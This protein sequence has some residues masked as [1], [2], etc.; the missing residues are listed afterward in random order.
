MIVISRCLEN[1]MSR[2]EDSLTYAQLCAEHPHVELWCDEKSPDSNWDYY[3]VISHP[4]NETVR[5]V[6]YLRTAN[7]QLERRRYDENGDEQWVS[8]R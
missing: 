5:N 3:W 1:R 4:D 2:I 6:A 8:V 7:D